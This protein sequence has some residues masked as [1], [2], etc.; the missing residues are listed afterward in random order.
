M[1]GTTIRE[2]ELLDGPQRSLRVHLITT[3]RLEVSPGEA[4]SCPSHI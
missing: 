2:P 3:A 4:S 1:L